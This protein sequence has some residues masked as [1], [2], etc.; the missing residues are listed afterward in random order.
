MNRRAMVGGAWLAAVGG[1]VFSALSGGCVA[2][3]DYQPQEKMVDELGFE[4][5]GKR[6][7]EVMTRAS[8]P[9]INAVNVA[10]DFFNYHW[11]QPII[12][13]YGVHMGYT[14]SFMQIFYANIAR[15]EIYENHYIFL[16]APDDAIIS[17]ILFATDQD[18]KI[19]ADLVMSFRARRLKGSASPPAPK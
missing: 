16:R 10:E 12:G 14:P 8:A 15:L 3:I 1:G 7:Q 2:V 17:Q 11:Q 18:A 13:P 4:E 9:R 19:Y 5:A 6:L